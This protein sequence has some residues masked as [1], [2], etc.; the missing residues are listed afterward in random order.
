M[1]V[2]PDSLPPV[3]ESDSSDEW[4]SAEEGSQDEGTGEYTCPSPG[5][6]KDKVIASATKL[7]LN[8]TIPE[9]QISC[10]YIYYIE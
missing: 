4:F 5:E 10:I 6:R 1:E 3:V 7:D 9:V 8:F 2:S